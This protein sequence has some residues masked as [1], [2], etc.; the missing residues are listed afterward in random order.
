M[1]L[2][3]AEAPPRDEV[4]ILQVPDAFRSQV[5]LAVDQSWPEATDAGDELLRRLSTL[6]RRYEE[7]PMTPDFGGGLPGD[8]Y[9]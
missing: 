6:A 7:R 9:P 5:Y 1:P 8:I 2:A 4:A 3:E